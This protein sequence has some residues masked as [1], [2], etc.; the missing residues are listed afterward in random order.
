MAR[1]RHVAWS[2]EGRADVAVERG[3]GCG[4]VA[5]MQPGAMADSNDK[6][7]SRW[8]MNG[9]VR[10]HYLEARPLA[11]GPAVLVVPGF[12]EEAADHLDLIEAVAPRRAVVVDLRGRGPSTV[13][14]GGYRIEDH[15]GDM[16][17]LVSAANIERLHLVMYS[18]G[19]TYGLAWAFA[20][21][22][23]LASI[24][25]ADYP[26]A[27]IVPP[28]NFAE[29]TAKR[30]WKGRPMTDRMP[31]VAIEA[32]LAD[33][34]NIEFWDEMAGLRVPV[35][36]IRGGAERAMV[37]DAILERYR[38][39]VVDLR[40]VTF[41]ESGHDLWSPD[42]HRFSATVKSFLDDVDDRSS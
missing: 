16:Q 19:T 13:T 36:L 15:A 40:V 4:T 20:H 1:V 6:P 10:L 30:V 32:L 24:T 18:R 11:R 12:G 5:A 34:V 33:A 7:V 28:A 17:A 39:A 27:Q 42:P 2:G 25:I 37:G 38:L 31:Q 22:E 26:A 8:A 29:M 3:D 41:E 9:L 21:A 35:Q 14:I 23:Q